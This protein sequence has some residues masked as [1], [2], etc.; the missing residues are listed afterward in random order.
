MRGQAGAV[1]RLVG[2]IEGVRAVTVTVPSA[3]T[4][5]PDEAATSTPEPTTEASPATG[6]DVEE[7]LS[8]LPKVEFDSGTS[9][10][11]ASSAGVL[12]QMA[13][14]ILTGPRTATY[15]VQGHTD[16]TGDSDANLNMSRQRAEAVLSALVERGVP[17]G[18]LEA[19]GYGATRLLV[20]PETTD[21]DRAANRRV[22]VVA[23]AG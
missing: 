22:V 16:T 1:E 3:A 21:A 23:T 11:S 17:A 13:R 5:E 10:L 12:D 14:A 2:G 7:Q 19:V 9:L 15:E 4:T 20:D 18:Q 8:G 6:G